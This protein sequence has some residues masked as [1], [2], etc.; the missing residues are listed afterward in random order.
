MSPSRIITEVHGQPVNN[1]DELIAVL[2]EQEDISEP[3]PLRM[4]DFVGRTSVISLRLDELYWP[5][6]L[7]SKEDT[8]WTTQFIFEKETE[9]MVHEAEE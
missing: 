9:D 6:Q 4:R 1:L 5:T 2:Q 3:I 7:F 8:S